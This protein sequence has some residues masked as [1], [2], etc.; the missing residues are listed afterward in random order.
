MHKL[1]IKV[2]FAQTARGRLSGG[3]QQKVV[4]AKW[5]VAGRPRVPVR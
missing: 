1:R 3:N 5:L 4:I 2:R